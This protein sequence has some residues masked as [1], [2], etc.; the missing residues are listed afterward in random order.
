MN[1]ISVSC[2]KAASSLSAPALNPLTIAKSSPFSTNFL[3]LA[4]VAAASEPVSIVC[5]CDVCSEHIL[6]RRAYLR[7]P[8]FFRED[9]AQSNACCRKTRVAIGLDTFE[10][11]N[12]VGHV[13]V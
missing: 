10:I 8:S 7:E 11:G 13:F 6:H 4:A 2:V 12:E 5:V 1:G 9:R 3:T